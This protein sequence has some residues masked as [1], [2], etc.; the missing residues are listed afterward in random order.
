MCCGKKNGDRDVK[1]A[2]HIYLLRLLELELE[3]ELEFPWRSTV[4][5]AAAI[6]H[7]RWFWSIFHEAAWS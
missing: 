4:E 6:F 3:L 1:S 7:W 5:F 2:R